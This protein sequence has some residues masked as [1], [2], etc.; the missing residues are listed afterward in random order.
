MPL[1]IDISVCASED[2]KSLGFSDST[3]IFNSTTNPAGYRATNLPEI[4]RIQTVAQGGGAGQVTG[5][6]YFRISDTQTNYYIWFDLD[7]GSTNPSAD[8]AGRTG[9]EVNISAGNT[10]ATVATNLA[11]AINA[12]TFTTGGFTATVLSDL[13]TITN[14]EDGATTDAADATTGTAA[15][16]FTFTILRQG[17]WDDISINDVSGA[18]IEYE[19]AG[20]TYTFKTFNA[21]TAGIVDITADTITVTA[22]GFSV[23]DPVILTSANS[24]ATLPGGLSINTV[25]YIINVGTNTIALAS[26]ALN[27]TAGTR[28]NLTSTGSGVVTIRHNVIN[29]FPTLP[30]IVSTAFAVVSADLRYTTSTSFPDGVYTIRYVITGNGGGTAFT[31]EVTREFLNYCGNKCCVYNM[32]AAIPEADCSCNSET[33]D[34]AIF[35]YTMLQALKNSAQAGQETRAANISATLAVLCKAENCTN[36][37]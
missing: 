9:I 7:N 26:S 37:P 30:N 3:G 13:V 11:A 23:R 32:V 33:V 29:V 21:T 19:V 34:R 35:A 27:A 6:D 14:V 16:N 4:T 17:T 2:C 5:G 10:A 20:V 15:T 25:Y 31:N 12:F 22:H 18:F 8:N 36:C 28:I 24:P 1:A